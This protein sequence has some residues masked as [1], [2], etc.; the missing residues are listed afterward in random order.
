[1]MIGVRLRPSDPG[2]RP[3]DINSAVS[4]KFRKVKSSLLSLC[5]TVCEYET[6]L[7]KGLQL[8]T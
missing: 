6:K 8:P 4:K 3:F 1:M 7:N 2:K 5:K